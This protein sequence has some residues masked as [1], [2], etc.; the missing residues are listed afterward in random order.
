[1]SVNWK[2]E[3]VVSFLYAQR[4]EQQRQEFL[5]QQLWR[6]K[7]LA[8]TSTPLLSSDELSIVWHP[9]HC[10]WADAPFPQQR[11]RS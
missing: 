1:M 10:P 8:G 3:Y 11:V 5:Q 4:I 6:D 7:R 2:H 9:L